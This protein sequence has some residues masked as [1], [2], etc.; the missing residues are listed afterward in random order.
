MIP[1]SLQP[2]DLGDQVTGAAE[3]F[4]SW[5]SAP[6]HAHH[7]CRVWPF[8]AM[9]VKQWLS[10]LRVSAFIRVLILE[11]FIYMLATKLAIKDS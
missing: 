7:H 6:T 11:N 8:V 2:L 10:F 5:G 4:G 9:A 1:L 3:L